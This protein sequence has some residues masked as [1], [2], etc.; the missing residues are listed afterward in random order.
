MPCNTERIPDIALEIVPKSNYLVLLRHLMKCL[1][2]ELRL[3]DEDAGQL[4]MCVDEAC[5][6][7][8]EAM[9]K[10]GI[11]HPVRLEI[12]MEDHCVRFTI[13]DNGLDYSHHFHQAKPM[14]EEADRSKRRGYGLRIIKTLMD[15]VDYFHDPQTGNR[16]YLVKYLTKK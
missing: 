2:H 10:H 13:C 6:N 1:A 12:E 7:S 4:E 3:T 8:V 9:N 5:A 11:L 15:E 16:L 14:T